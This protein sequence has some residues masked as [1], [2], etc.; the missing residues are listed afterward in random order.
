VLLIINLFNYMDR[1]VLAALVEPIQK[2]LHATNEQMGWTATAFLASY[3]IL[4][5]IFGYLADRF[6]RWLLVAVGV[7]LWSLA[8]GATGLATTFFALIMT[9]CFVG[10]GEAAYGPVAPT[11]LS[12]LY[13]VQNR[14]RTL[15]FFYMA[16]PVGSALG[17]VLGGWAGDLV[18]WHKTFFLL[19]PPG[20]LLAAWSLFMKEPQRGLSDHAPARRPSAHEYLQLAT[21]RSY[22]LDTLGFSAM[23]FALGG[24]GMW[25]PKF[26]NQQHT[27]GSLKHI[28]E[29][30][31]GIV[32]LAGLL[33]TFAGGWLGDKFRDRFPGS[34]FLVC[35]FGMI[36]GFPMVLLMLFT[37]FPLAWVWVFLACFFLFLNTGPANTILANVTHP[38]IRASAFAINILIIHTFGD[39]I[40]PVVIGAI[41]DRWSLRTGFMVVSIAMLVGGLIWLMGARYLE[42]DTKRISPD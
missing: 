34:Y 22:V 40:S 30:F 1:Q 42:E 17:Y 15:A 14:G 37:P 28:D 4:S 24:I 25:M 7:A 11:L 35:G 33:A 36:V 31:G 13:P 26:I 39:A 21:N 41:A 38:S 16:I 23:T 32:V 5:P 6:S 29:T 19:V 3:M 12:D 9:R 20:M 10:V 2:D 18:G 27:A 8:S